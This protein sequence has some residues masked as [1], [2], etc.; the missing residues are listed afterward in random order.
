MHADTRD[1]GP[2]PGAGATDA[3]DDELFGTCTVMAIL[4]GYA[5]V[6]AMRLAHRAWDVGVDLVEVTVETPDALSTLAAVVAGGRERGRRVGAGTVITVDQVHAV[7]D[8][9][10][11]FTVAP[12]LDP[13]VV[14]SCRD[15]GLVHLPGVATSTEVQQAL[16]LGLRWLKAFPASVLG[17]GWF[18]AMRGPFPQVRFVATG[19]MDAANG[20]DFL[21]AGAR[22]VAVG[23]ALADSQQIAGLGELVAHQRPVPRR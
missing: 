1:A 7:A 19:G 23:S 3:D 18:L 14:A 6:E 22:M 4:R 15:H 20:R 2:R 16:G 13:E 9:G 11:A 8:L 12:G 17:V 10:A 21:A 5:P